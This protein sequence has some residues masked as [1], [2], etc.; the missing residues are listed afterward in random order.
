[1]FQHSAANLFIYTTECEC[2]LNSIL[3]YSNELEHTN[4]SVLILILINKRH[5]YISFLVLNVY[6]SLRLLFRECFVFNT[7]NNSILTKQD[8]GLMFWNETFALGIH[9]IFGV[10]MY[11]HLKLIFLLVC[12]SVAGALF[13]FLLNIMTKRR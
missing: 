7:Q 8:S 12:M 5:R 4:H 2:V 11:D 1:M 13:G 10:P 9:W 6:F 3:F